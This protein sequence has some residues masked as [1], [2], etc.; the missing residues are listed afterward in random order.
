MAYTLS[1]NANIDPPCIEYRSKN[2]INE[3]SKRRHRYPLSD[4]PLQW[5]NEFQTFHLHRD[6][7]SNQDWFVMSP[8]IA[9]FANQFR[10]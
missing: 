5:Q 8:P 2:R 1:E 6:L 9:A 7:K 3:S 10:Y 4:F